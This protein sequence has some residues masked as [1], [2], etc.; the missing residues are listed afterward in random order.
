M[1]LP[2]RRRSRKDKRALFAVLG[3]LLL[4]LAAIL[5]LIARAGDLPAHLV[6]NQVL[7]FVLW[8]VNGILILTILFV[9]LRNLYKLAVER[10]SRI[11]GSK[12][13]VKLVFTFV[14][15]SLIPVLLL[16]FIAIELFQD[17]ADRWFSTQ[18][19][20]V[21]EQGY[22]VA[23]ALSDHIEQ[24]ALLD[25]RRVRR[26]VVDLDLSDPASRPELVRRLRELM[27]DGGLDVLAVYDGREFVQA[28][29]DP[30]T[31]IADLPEPPRDLL[32]EA[33][34]EGQAVGLQEPPGVPGTLVLAAAGA[35]GVVGDEPPVDGDAG[36]EP[37][38]VPP[39]LAPRDPPAGAVVVAGVL[40]DPALAAQTRELRE[41][42][43]AYRQLEV[44]RD[45]LATSHLLTFLMVTLLILLASSWVGL[46]LARRVTVP[47]QA[48]AEGTRRISHGDLDHR[49]EVA[50]EDELGVLVDSFNR[51]TRQLK[52]SNQ[53]LVEANRRVREERALIGAVLANVAAGVVS[54]DADGRIFTCNS[55]ALAMLRQREEEVI[56]RHY[57]EA[58]SDPER[59][60]LA[61]LLTPVTPGGTPPRALV[62]RGRHEASREVHL[63]VGGRWKALEVKVTL[64]PGSGPDGSDRLG[65]KSGGGQVVVLEDLTELIQAQQLAAWSEAA[66]RIAHEIKNPLT[67][68]KLS[69]ER[70]LRRYRQDDPRLGEALEE[71]VETIVREVDTLQAMVD[72][73]SRYA[74]MPRPH[75]VPVDVG[76]LVGETLDLYRDLKE[77]VE[78]EAR[79]DPD[80]GEVPLDPQQMRRALINLLDNA[81]EATEP[82]GRVTVSA[83]RSDGHLEIHV[84]DTGRGIP[85]EA[86][87]K[88]FLPYFST[89]GRGTG[90]GLAIVHRIVADHQ[91]SI[92]VE[93]NRPRGSV[94]TVELPLP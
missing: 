52:S 73:F 1:E 55:A 16:F 78:V 8:Y 27:A 68:I 48:L 4:L 90:L 19:S 12:F 77:G 50:A 93:D 10:R 84:A 26:Q 57:Q 81:L 14:G 30:R 88:L 70:M 43:L 62:R 18:V 24:Q 36:A 51:M 42:F 40:L 35:P 91:G 80:V 17:S 22:A 32:L 92:R 25:A 33:L 89:K 87:D 76:K 72:E 61:A 86:K 59:A 29:V 65:P 66:R 83:E 82:P 45:N 44:Q 85:A 54:I 79:M 75:P 38:W 60:R 49:V 46:Y 53:E 63:F 6:T 9:L 31:G 64:L 21:R 2:P 39:R 74:R 41:A 94:F 23:E 71:G 56:G 5:F 3:G 15:L 28:V 47:I 34:A 11:L 37:P 67:P 13:K 69:A 7:L 58:W 20:E